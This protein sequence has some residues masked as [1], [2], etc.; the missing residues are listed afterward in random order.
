MIL[1]KKLF[2][3][4]SLLTASIIYAAGML[5]E[6]TFIVK[7]RRS[8]VV[9]SERY[10]VGRR[11]RSITPESQRFVDVLRAVH[12]TW[13]DDNKSVPLAIVPPETIRADK[14]FVQSLGE[15]WTPFCSSF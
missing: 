10:L 3:T 11:R 14:A 6:Q 8:R 1:F 4:F 15:V 13:D 5:F 7:P 12:A 2:D 9:N